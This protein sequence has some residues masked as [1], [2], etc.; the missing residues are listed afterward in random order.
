LWKELKKTR[1]RT[2]L[3]PYLLNQK[4]R[5]IKEKKRN[6]PADRLSPGGCSYKR[7]LVGGK[8]E[9]RKVYFRSLDWFEQE[10]AG[11]SSS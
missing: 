4:V 9:R 5:I 8:Q 7:R 1:E 10:G 3:K 6:F 11:F 2:I